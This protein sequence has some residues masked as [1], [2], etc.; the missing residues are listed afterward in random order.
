MALVYMTPSL[1]WHILCVTEFFS[2][3]LPFIQLRHLIMQHLKSPFCHIKEV[4][5]AIIPFIY[6]M[7][8]CNT[9]IFTWK[10]LENYLVTSLIIGNLMIFRVTSVEWTWLGLEWPPSYSFVKLW[11]WRCLQHEWDY[12]LF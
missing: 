12:I 7:Y 9:S 6:V 5:I 10:L 8:I 3:K 1:L 2:L 11:A 4:I